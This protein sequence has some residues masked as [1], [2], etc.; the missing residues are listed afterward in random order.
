MAPLLDS[1]VNKISPQCGDQA[2]SRGFSQMAQSME[3]STILFI[4]NQIRE[5]QAEGIAVA[6]MTV[7]DF[8]P[9]EFPI[10]TEFADLVS[11]SVLAGNNNYPPSPGTKELR[12]A[13]KDHVLR[14]QG[15][16]Y[17][18]ESFTFMSGGRPSLY[19][20]YRLLV[21]PGDLVVFP[22]PS[23]NNHNYR[24]ACQVQ[25]QG[26]QCRPEDAFQPTAELMRP[27]IGKARLLVLNTPQNPSG[28]V[29]PKEEMEAFGHLMV[30]ENQR[31][32]ATGE[33][34]LFLLFDQIY[35]SLVFPG[36][37]H[38]SPVSLV[39]ECAPY[40]I[41]SD[42]ISKG[43][44]ATGLRCGWIFGPPAI[45]KKITALL[46]HL[47]AWSPKPVQ[48]ATAQWLSN[49]VACDL[50]DQAMIEKVQSRLQILHQG[51]ADLKE[52]GLPLDFIAPQGAI[53]MSVQ[54][55]CEGMKTANGT[56][57]N[58]NESIRDYLLKEA[59]FAVVPFHAFGVEPENEDGWCRVSVGAV[60]SQDISDAMPR[61]RKALAALQPSS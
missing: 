39:P 11:K 23:W 27:H 2:A 3:G 21:D 1:P 26:I 7:G 53:Y 31:R 22:V 35:R 43:M 37:A 4:A 33:K 56:L 24:D 36:H 20:T 6:N 29:M 50:W 42:G 58:N 13:L 52:E 61:L 30:E 60:G 10:P 59:K 18:L 48:L 28:G 15:L 46:T 49:P 44:C 34:P 12:I 5:M 32:E 51:L 41:H 40:V 55:Q 45:A 8:N 57:L 38:Y 17:P 54:F 19:A 9:A 16:D 25:V 47:G 14:T